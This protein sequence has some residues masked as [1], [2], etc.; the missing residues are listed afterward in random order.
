MTCEPRK[1]IAPWQDKTFHFWVQLRWIKI[2]IVQPLQKRSVDRGRA[3]KTCS[4][5][6]VCRI[7]RPES[8]WVS[9]LGEIIQ[10]QFRK[11]VSEVCPIRWSG[12]LVT[13]DNRVPVQIL[14]TDVSQ[15]GLPE[16]SCVWTPWGSGGSPGVWALGEYKLPP[17]AGVQN[18]PQTRKVSSGKPGQEK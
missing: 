11:V 13:R 7:R 14:N 3:C 9:I 15:G 12:R 1:S 6:W 5:G 4:F 16:A 17:S 8:R 18:E 10:V 2:N